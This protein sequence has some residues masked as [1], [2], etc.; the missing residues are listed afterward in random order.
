MEHHRHVTHGHRQRLL[1]QEFHWRIGTGQDEGAVGDLHNQA[2]ERRP[3]L[4]SHR[5]PIVDLN[6]S[7]RLQR[8]VRWRAGPPRSATHW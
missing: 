2:R 3:V 8:V 7:N 6:S 5:H 4:E 1:L